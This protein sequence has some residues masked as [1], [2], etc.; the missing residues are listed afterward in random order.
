[1]ASQQ[2]LIRETILGMAR[3]L[4]R[5]REGKSFMNRHHGPDS[6]SVC[7]LGLPNSESEAPHAT[8]RGQKLKRRAEYYHEGEIGGRLPQKRVRVAVQITISHRL[9]ASVED[10]AR[11]I[12]PVHSQIQPQAI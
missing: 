2:V 5:E 1:M 7:Y 8:N 12:Q 6:S 10:R 3:R 11:G 9:T 4:T